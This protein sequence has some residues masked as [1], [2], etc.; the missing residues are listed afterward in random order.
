MTR[1]CTVCQNPNWIQIRFNRG[2]SAERRTEGDVEFTFSNPEDAQETP[3]ASCKS[4]YMI[5]SWLE[6]MG[7]SRTFE[8][9]ELEL[10]NDIRSIRELLDEPAE[11]KEQ[12]EC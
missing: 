9:N 1:L 4:E 12:T 8:A 7:G 3:G 11:S 2:K 6:R 5:M 10:E